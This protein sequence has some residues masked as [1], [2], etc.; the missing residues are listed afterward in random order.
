[1]RIQAYESQGAVSVIY[2][3]EWQREVDFGELCYAEN[4][5]E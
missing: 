1:M 2:G 3:V 4:Y 5:G